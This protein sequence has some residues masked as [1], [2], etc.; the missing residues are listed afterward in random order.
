MTNSLFKKAWWPWPFLRLYWSPLFE[1]LYTKELYTKIKENTQNQKL[2]ISIWTFLPSVCVLTKLTLQIQ[3]IYFFLY[4]QWMFCC[5]MC[6]KQ[7]IMFF[8]QPNDVY[9]NF[10]RAQV[11]GVWI[12]WLDENRKILI[13]WCTCLT[14]YGDSWPQ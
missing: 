14:K 4:K 12:N 3:L 11:V 6:S 10:V 2:N 1:E 7:R 8:K 5:K 9:W 13:I